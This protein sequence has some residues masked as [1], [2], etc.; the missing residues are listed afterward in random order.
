MKILLCKGRFAG[1]I[2][3]ADETVVTYA[4]QLHAA[5]H[6]VSVVLLHP[7]SRTDSYYLRLRAAG[8]PVSFVVHNSPLHS[9]LRAVRSRIPHIPTGPRR[10]LHKTSYALAKS[11]FEPCKAYF[12]QCGAALIHVMTPD[13]GA[14]TMIKAA[15]ATGIPVLYQELGTAHYLPELEFYYQQ[16]AQVLPLCTE[17]AALSPL[18]ARQFREKFPS[19][20]RTSVIPLIVDDTASDGASRAEAPPQARAAVVFGFAARLEYGKGPL[21]LI[22]AF[23]RT[24]ARL[25]H[26]HLKMAGAGPQEQQAKERGKASG[27]VKSCEFCGIYTGASQQSAFMRSLDVFVLPTLAEGTP[28]SIIEAMAHGLPIVSSAVGGIPDVVTPDTGILTAPG[29]VDA[30][31]DALT[32]LAQ[33]PELRARMGHAARARY[34]KLFSPGAA[35]PV[36][37]QAYQRVASGAATDAQAVC[38][39]DW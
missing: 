37:L 32:C 3:G 1:P 34:E 24:H 10:V 16:L 11:Y 25:P 33:N 30:L 19:P 22:D 9:F 36:L 12:A 26:T 38:P 5:G 18:L 6:D 21:L 29:D 4:T 23:A 14:I 20:A 39:K 31:D 15:H 7:Y 27:L 8:V 28:N 35:L 13:P 2:S 17:V